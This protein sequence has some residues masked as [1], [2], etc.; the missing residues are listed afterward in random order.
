MTDQEKAALQA[1]LAKALSLAS[2]SDAEK[3]YLKT[4][5][6]AKQ[7]EFV[8]TEIDKRADFVK[9]NPI[10]VD[11]GETLIVAG[12]TIKKSEVGAV[13][14]G[15]LK[16]QNAQISTISALLTSTTTALETETFAKRAELEYPYLPGTRE[17]KGAMLAEIEKLPEVAKRATLASL[18]AASEAIKYQ[19]TEVGV[20]GVGTGEPGAGTAAAEMEALVTKYRADHPTAGYDVAYTEVLKANAE[21]YDRMEAEKPAASK[22]A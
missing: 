14:F 1:Q 12:Q 6:T 15:V 21:L 20:G 9:A 18:K 13:M 10:I 3:T 5:T 7:D 2:M 19:S 11:D 16:A 4:L 22:A 17:E 8:A